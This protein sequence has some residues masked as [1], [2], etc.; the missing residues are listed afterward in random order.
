MEDYG[1]QVIPSINLRELIQEIEK[2]RTSPVQKDTQPTVSYIAQL[3]SNLRKE[4]IYNVHGRRTSHIHECTLQD[5]EPSIHLKKG[6]SKDQ[7]SCRAKE[8]NPRSTETPD[9]SE[10]RGK[11][12]KYASILQV[13]RENNRNVIAKKKV[14]V[15][16]PL[17]SFTP[18]KLDYLV[19]EKA[20]CYQ[21]S[22][23]P[24]SKFYANSLYRQSL[25]S[26]VLAP[27]VVK[28]TKKNVRSRWSSDV[29]TSTDYLN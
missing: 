22:R 27:I 13:I 28:V 23:R 10:A 1:F 26:R 16:S 20:K 2:E 18:S 7:Y 29:I 8:A 15:E 17:R 24:V 5:Q 3:C 6:L 9:I 21:R 4:P 19:T 11:S 14:R 12:E 25:K